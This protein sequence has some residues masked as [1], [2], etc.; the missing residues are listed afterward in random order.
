[1]QV[2]FFFLALIFGKE[3]LYLISPA[4]ATGHIVLAIAT[5]FNL[6]TT[7]G[8][9]SGQLLVGMGRTFMIPVSQIA[10]ICASLGLNY[11][12]V[13]AHGAE[14]AALATGIAVLIGSLVTFIGAWHYC[15]APILQRKYVTAL[16]PG[17]CLYSAAAALHWLARPGLA[18]DI[19][20]FAAA[21][22]FFAWDA[23]RRWHR[24][25]ADHA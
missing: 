11:L 8:A 10:F 3:L 19:A 4:Y 5:F 20:A 1:V 21:S 24:F 12:I 25:N 9:F 23:R 6:A 2:P 22:A 14:G 17:L 16:V 13:P 18:A 15:G 7:V